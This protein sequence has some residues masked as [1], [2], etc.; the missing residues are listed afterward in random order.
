MLIRTCSTQKIYHWALI[1]LY[2]IKCSWTD[3]MWEECIQSMINI[4]LGM[5][6]YRTLDS[7]IIIWRHIKTDCTQRLASPHPL[8]LSDNNWWLFSK[9]TQKRIQFVS[10]DL[11]VL[12]TKWIRISLIIEEQ[13][14]NFP[15]S[16]D[17]TVTFE[18][19]SLLFTKPFSTRTEFSHK[20]QCGTFICT[21]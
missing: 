14:V 13:K 17:L 4:S 5:Y 11:K 8:T 6:H 7:A 9:V 2:W 3:M 19:D 21:F 10:K 20:K 12:C 15:L 16:A 18:T 1:V